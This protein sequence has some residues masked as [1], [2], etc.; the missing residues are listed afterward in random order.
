MSTNKI[1]GLDHL[2]ALAITLVFLF[3]YRLFAHPEWVDTIGSFGWTGVDL[4]FVL[5]GYLIASQVFSRLKARDFF[6]SDFF[7]SR[8]FRIIPVYLLVLTLYFTLPAFREWEHLAPLW[9]YVTFTQNLG[10]DLRTQRTF[11]HAWSLCIEEQFYL[12]FPLIA[13]GAAVA[14]ARTGVYLVLFLFIAGFAA[15]WLS[16]AYL[17]APLQGTGEFGANWYKWIYYPTYNRLDGL[18]T[19]I[20]IAGIMNYYP[21][22][23]AFMLRHS[24]A[25]LFTGL[26]LLTGAYYLCRQQQSFSASVF[27]FPLVSIGFGFVAAASIGPQASLSTRVLV[28]TG[29][30]AAWSYSLYLIHKAV[31]H[32]VQE[33]C[34]LLGL[35]K[36]GT[37][38][39]WLGAAACCVTAAALYYTVERPFMRIRKMLLKKRAAKRILVADATNVAAPTL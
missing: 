1:A 22:A 12:L 9:K 37:P 2:R 21:V 5:S 36:E 31:I 33:H 25:L 8:F 23:A 13:A 34:S 4:F 20:T 29:P 26:G 18:L 3:H 19:G 32:F 27:G 30:I 14:A 35:D 11:S 6:I 39:F 10:L 16:W 24:R 7:I 28:I 15:R 38:V 17:A